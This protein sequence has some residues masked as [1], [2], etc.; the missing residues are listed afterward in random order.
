MIQNTDT[1]ILF[2][3]KVICLFLMCEEQYLFFFFHLKVA[4]RGMEKKYKDAVTDTM[5]QLELN[6]GKVSKRST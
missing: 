3:T 4:K 2:I 6:G 5:Q 1:F